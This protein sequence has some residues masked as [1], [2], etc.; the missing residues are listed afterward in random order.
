MKEFFFILTIFL[1]FP[2]VFAQEYPDLGVKVE[3]VADNLDIPWSIAWAPD[4]TVFFTERSG[5]LKVIQNG[6]LL[7]EAI[8][9]LD[10]GGVEGG[11]LG[12]SLDPN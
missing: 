4:N 5:H 9:S 8:F 1:G 7:E 6:E 3:V 11:L 2:T 12:V 10:V